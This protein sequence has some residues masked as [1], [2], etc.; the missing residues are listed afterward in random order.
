MYTAAKAVVLDT[1]TKGWEVVGWWWGGEEMQ[2]AWESDTA[3]KGLPEDGSL[4]IGEKQCCRL[5]GNQ[6]KQS[7]LRKPLDWP[8]RV[9][10]RMANQGVR[11]LSRAGKVNRA[12]FRLLCP[13]QTSGTFPV[14]SGNLR[15][16]R[17]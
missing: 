1:A 6:R 3:E 4:Q 16:R 2:S 9:T 11:R 10:A 8:C 15:T 17:K 7:P 12:V 13:A 5:E 14:C